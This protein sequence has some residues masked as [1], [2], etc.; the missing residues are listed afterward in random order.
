MPKTLSTKRLDHWFPRKKNQKFTEIDCY[1]APHNKREEVAEKASTAAFK[2]PKTH[3][4]VPVQMTRMSGAFTDYNKQFRK[5][6]SQPIVTKYQ[7]FNTWGNSKAKGK[8]HHD[9]M[10]KFED[11]LKFKRKPEPKDKQLNT[12]AVEEKQQIIT[13]GTE[14][15]GY[16][17]LD[18]RLA[19]M[20]IKR[21]MIKDNRGN[22]FKSGGYYQAGRRF[23]QY[24]KETQ[25]FDEKYI[26]IEEEPD[27][28]SSLEK[29][30]EQQRLRYSNNPNIKTG[31]LGI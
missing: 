16:K 1:V 10:T 7:K 26:A 5:K 14:V 23:R 9:K 28:F 17:K 15:R 27:E 19:K 24:E 3:N 31:N 2:M 30:F 18:K 21:D 22:L 29:A 4:K 11:K 8:Y 20:N 6:R 25:R 12:E 13:T